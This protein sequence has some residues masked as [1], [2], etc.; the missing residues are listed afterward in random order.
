[1][2]MF[3][4]R[5]IAGMFIGLITFQQAQADWVDNAMMASFATAITGVACLGAFSTLKNDYGYWLTDQELDVRFARAQRSMEG[6][7][8]QLE[9]KYA[10]QVSDLENG[11][12][13]LVR[14]TAI[15]RG[16]ID[17]VNDIAHDR[18]RLSR[19]REEL[20]QCQYLMSSR[21]DRI[22]IVQLNMQCSQAL[23]YV[24]SCNARLEALKNF[25]QSMNEYKLEVRY[26]EAQRKLEEERQR[27]E[28]ERLKLQAERK[29]REETAKREAAKREAE[30]KEAEA[31]REA[32]RLAQAVANYFKPAPKETV[33]YHYAKPASAPKHE[34]VHVYS[35]PQEVVYHHT[36][37]AG[38]PSAPPADDY[39]Y[40]HVEGPVYHYGESVY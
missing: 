1:M 9:L 34:T 2:T 5:T 6:M 29:A 25:V 15:A 32:E 12:R 17:Y 16:C 3:H 31:V 11:T 21:L 10:T 36:V 7:L 13:A 39:Y 24:E 27:L 38:V 14:S 19:V 35:A 40:A 26:Q 4:K 8:H 37:P 28:A 30:R 23:R 20:A 22:Y 33:V 18:S